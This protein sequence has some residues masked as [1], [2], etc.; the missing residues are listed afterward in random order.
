MPRF[1]I[2]KKTKDARDLSPDDQ[3]LLVMADILEKTAVVDKKERP[4]YG[5]TLIQNYLD[6][7]TAKE[8]RDTV[9]EIYKILHH[10]GGTLPIKA[11]INTTRKLRKVF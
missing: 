7:E 8:K 6:T 4:G 1:D 5:D 10:A 3:T 11:K 9:Y 2:V